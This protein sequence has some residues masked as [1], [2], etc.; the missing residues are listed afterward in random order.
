[1]VLQ[2]YISEEETEGRLIH[3]KRLLK[4]AVVILMTALL[5]GPCISAAAEETALVTVKANEVKEGDASVTVTCDIEG[6]NRVSSGKIRIRYDAEKM[7]LKSAQAGNALTGAMCEINDCLK[8]SKE[9]GELVVAFASASRLSGDGSLLNLVFNLD[10]SVKEGTILEVTADVEELAGDD[11]DVAANTINLSAE[12]TRKDSGGEQNPSEGEDEITDGTVDSE[13]DTNKAH[14]TNKD[15]TV[16][17]QKQQTAAKDAD[18]NSTMSKTRSVKTKDETNILFP[19]VF[20][21]AALLGIIAVGMGK[22]SKT[23]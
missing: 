11:A 5:T 13:K 14:D 2:T 16:N 10:S 7:R 1:M 20:T 15:N 6:G 18:K 9:E 17:T 12:V 23:K 19:A 21:G 8:G 22:K 4:R 3:M